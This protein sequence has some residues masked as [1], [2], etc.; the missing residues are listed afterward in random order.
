ML[1]LVYCDPLN[2]TCPGLLLR[3]NFKN[4][5]LESRHWLSNTVHCPMFTPAIAHS[6]TTLSFPFRVELG[7]FFRHTMVAM[8]LLMTNFFLVRG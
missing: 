6:A 5:H 1:G 3:Q 7:G 2:L 8:W 4:A